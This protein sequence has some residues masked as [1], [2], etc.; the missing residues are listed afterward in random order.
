MGPSGNDQRTFQRPRVVSQDGSTCRRKE[1]KGHPP[2]PCTDPE[3]RSG[4][5]LPVSTSTTNNSTNF[6][7]R[8]TV[9]NQSPFVIDPGLWSLDEGGWF[10]STILPYLELVLTFSVTSRGEVGCH[11]CG[12]EGGPNDYYFGAP[13][14]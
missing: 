2:T 3:E 1:T 8:R 5:L 6:P 9:R 4:L 13:K 14:V 7:K 12:K 10:R 11:L